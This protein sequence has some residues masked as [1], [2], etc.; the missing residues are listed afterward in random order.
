MWQD[1]DF[2][3]RRGKEF[4][5]E[6]TSNDITS[7]KTK[8]INVLKMFTESKM[9]LDDV[10]TNDDAKKIVNQLNVV[11]RHNVDLIDSLFKLV[12]NV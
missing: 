7:L 12:D 11:Y 3:D 9:K 8:Y 10:N 6:S 1:D 4:Q 2:I 5:I